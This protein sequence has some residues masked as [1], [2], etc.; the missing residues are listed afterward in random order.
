MAIKTSTCSSSIGSS[1]LLYVYDK[2]RVRRRVRR[3]KF[4]RDGTTL[5]QDYFIHGGQI[6]DGRSISRYGMFKSETQ[7]YL[8]QGQSR[9][10]ETKHTWL[11]QLSLQSKLG[12]ALFCGSS[13]SIYFL[14]I[15]VN[16]TLRTPCNGV[17]VSFD[18][19]AADLCVL[20]MSLS[21]CLLASVDHRRIFFRITQ[22]APN[23]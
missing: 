20:P 23:G 13:C 5:L 12:R 7:H 3:L 21:I 10:E 6:L 2:R 11:V 19:I 22:T 14:V 16:I 1:V 15:N 8:Q 9:R 17:A 4:D 18:T